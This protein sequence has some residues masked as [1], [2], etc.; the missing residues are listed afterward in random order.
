[1]TSRIGS[2]RQPPT[3]GHEHVR[4]L[5]KPRH[6]GGAEPNQPVAAADAARPVAT[7]P[8]RTAR[9]PRRSS[10]QA[11]CRPFDPGGAR[12]RRSEARTD[13]R[14]AGAEQTS[15]ARASGKRPRMR[16]V[17]RVVESGAVPSGFLRRAGPR[18]DDGR[19]PGGG[20]GNVR[21]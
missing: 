19:F 10:A 20:G 21:G 7:R 9:C 8:R 4:S 2:E 3:T 1:M 16:S 6:R 18:R 13:A 15:T 14:C 17:R 12:Q 11:H 5:W